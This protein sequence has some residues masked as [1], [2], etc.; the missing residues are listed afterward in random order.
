MA[1][2]WVVWMVLKM[3]EMMVSRTECTWVA[4]METTTAA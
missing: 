2:M 1:A 3:V 4:Q